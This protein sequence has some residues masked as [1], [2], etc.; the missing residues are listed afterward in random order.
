M[1]KYY[2]VLNRIAD[3]KY[4]VGIFSIG[5]NFAKMPRTST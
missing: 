3:K 4:I 5:Y 2:S 1:F